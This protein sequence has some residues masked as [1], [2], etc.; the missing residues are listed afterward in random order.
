MNLKYHNSGFLQFDKIDEISGSS[1]DNMYAL[2][3]LN[4]KLPLL[5]LSLWKKGWFIDLILCLC[6]RNIHFL[7]RFSYYI[8]IVPCSM[9]P[10]MCWWGCKSAVWLPPK[11]HF[12]WWSCSTK[13]SVCRSFIFSCRSDRSK[14]QLKKL[15]RN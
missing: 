6:F 4:Y 12:L 14:L 10:N 11:I 8:V 2:V 15:G 3:I 13:N 5:T 7:W 9:F 1:N